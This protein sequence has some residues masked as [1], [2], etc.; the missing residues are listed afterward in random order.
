MNIKT[1][2]IKTLVDKKNFTRQDIYKAIYNAEVM[3][4]IFYNAEVLHCKMFWFVSSPIA[5]STC[6]Y[7]FF[8]FSQVL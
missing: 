3:H 5:L 6:E 4:Y 1:K 2:V 8:K 7:V